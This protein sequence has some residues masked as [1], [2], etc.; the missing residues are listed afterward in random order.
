MGQVCE[1]LIDEFYIVL[2]LFIDL[3]VIV[4]FVVEMFG[5][6]EFLLVLG[7]SVSKVGL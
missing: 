7:F 2:N 3:M 6:G 1:V 4:L 5:I